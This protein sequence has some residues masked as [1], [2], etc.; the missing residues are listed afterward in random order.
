ME[1]YAEILQKRKENTMTNYDMDE[2]RRR[3]EVPDEAW[4]ERR[5][6]GSKPN[7]P[8]SIELGKDETPHT[9]IDI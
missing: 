5:S 2:M 3:G 1:T 7:W 4:S 6:S 9:S 8:Q